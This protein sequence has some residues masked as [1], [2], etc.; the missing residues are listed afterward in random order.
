M[1]NRILHVG[2]QTI[3]WLS[4]LFIGFLTV[5]SLLSTAYFSKETSFAE[6]PQY[7]MDSVLL[8][9]L[10]LLAALFFCYWFLKGMRT[11]GS[12]EKILVLLVTVF[13]I[14]VSLLWTA[15]S[16]TYPEADQK[17]VSWVAYLTSQN[18]FLFFE[19]GKYMQ[20]YPNQLGLTAILEGL[21]RLAG[22]ENHKLF[23][24]VTALSNGAVVYLLYKITKKLFHSEKI[25][26]LVLLLSMGCIQIMLYTTFLYGIMLG[27]SL[28]L[29]SFLFLLYCLEEKTW[30][31]KK[32]LY[33]FLS[34][35]LIGLSIQV[36][37]NYSIFLVALALLL[38]YKALEQRKLWP[39][40]MAFF[41]IFTSALMGK[42]LTAFYEARS[43]IPITGGMP[44]TLWI[45][46]GMQEGER[47]EGWYNGFNYNTFLKTD[48]DPKKSSAI[49][50]E[51]I[52]E[53]LEGFVSDPLYALSFYYKKTASQWNEPTYEALWV[54]QFHQGD[55]SVIVQSIYE[56][57]LYTLL[58]EYMNGY[59]SLIFGAAFL[60]LLYRRRSFKPE[61][62][63]LLL[64]ILGGFAF[65]TLWEAK[66]QYIFPYFVILL[67]YGAAGIVSLT[68]Q[69]EEIRRKRD[70][71]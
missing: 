9:G 69:M 21:Y 37:N 46:M 11:E 20:I 50:K 43:G 15:V 10:F 40:L 48:C 59:Q 66:S 26:A 42:G 67:P 39:V 19:H 34:A 45:A 65:H 7:R 47:A 62:L 17:A 38:L 2:K 28:A 12:G 1:E 16:H 53:S 33:G 29:A 27:L 60:C 41:L 8:N 52:E 6:H 61:Q 22:E 24:Y 58:H 63:F 14:G 30:G 36:K 64:V 23:M 3:I 54:N 32:L 25:N 57:K 51:A 18:N 4:I 31:G 35:V 44:K 56:G 55:F 68:G 70:D 49:A 5:I 71:R 13:V